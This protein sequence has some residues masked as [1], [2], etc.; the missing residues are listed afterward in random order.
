MITEGRI[1]KALS[2]ALSFLE[3]TQQPNGSFL[4]LSS[5]DKN[6]LTNSVELHSVFSTALILQCLSVIPKK[7]KEATFV[8]RKAIQFLLSQCSSGGTWNYWDRTAKQAQ[9]HPYPDDLDDTF[10]ALAALFLIDKSLI[11]PQTLARS[12]TLLTSLEQKVGGPYKTWV[13]PNN[14]SAVWRDID[15]VVNANIAY[16]LSLFEIQLPRLQRLFSKAIKTKSFTTPYYPESLPV[17]FFLSRVVSS[18][19]EIAE[20]IKHIDSLDEK[21]A[22]SIALKICS[23]CELQTPLFEKKQLVAQLLNTQHPDG[24][25]PAATFY[26][27]VGKT[28]TDKAFAGSAALTTAFSIQALFYFLT[29]ENVAKRN[30]SKKSFQKDDVLYETICKRLEERFDRIEQPLRQHARQ[31]LKHILTADVDRQVTLLPVCVARNLRIKRSVD[32]EVLLKLGEASVYGW[33]AYTIYDDFLDEEG[34]LVLLPLANVCLRELSQIFSTVLPSDTGFRTYFNRVMDSL[35]NAN[36]WEILNCRFS[37]SLSAA[38]IPAFGDYHQLANKSLGHMLASV[39]VFVSAGFSITSEEVVHLTSFFKHFL[40][41]RQLDDD[42][43]DWEEDLANGHIN[44]AGA[45]VLQGS[46]E[47]TQLKEYFWKETISEVCSLMFSHIAKAR[48]SLMQLEKV[49]D[50]SLFE[51]MLLKHERSAIHAQEEKQKALTFIEDYFA[52]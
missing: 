35:E 19:K 36:A 29:E 6:F 9:S 11:T 25:F 8:K 12:T 18:E 21:D 22:L 3:N 30:E 4:S 24:S 41:V 49:F 5:P 20:M 31:F 16:F 34:K 45:L 48:A 38:S 50:I 33:I 28:A 14:A 13:L 32:S 26:T 10:C 17:L 43:H 7:Q 51:R 52:S 39:A 27:G 23:Y 46:R 37:G 2:Q 40:I 1:E 44:A 47:K 15:L 42:A